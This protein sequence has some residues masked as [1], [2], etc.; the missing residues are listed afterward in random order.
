MQ[1][2]SKKPPARSRPNARIALPLLS[3]VVTLT[4]GAQLSPPPND[5]R[6]AMDVERVDLHLSVQ[7]R[8]GR[9]VPGLDQQHFQVFEDG[10]RQQIRYFS[11][12]DVPVTVGLLLDNSR[13]MGPKRREAVA[14]ALVFVGS[15]NLQD[16]VFVV[17]FN[18][19]VRFGLPERTLFSNDLQQLRA[20]FTRLTPDGQTA[21]YDALG[22]ALK[23]AQKGRRDKKVL[24]VISDGGDNA[25]GTEFDQIWDEVR[26]RDIIVYAIGLYDQLNKD[27]DPKV[28]KRL[29]GATGGEAFFPARVEDVIRICRQI[30]GE[31]RAQY[32]LG[33]APLNR[34][35]DGAYRKIRVVARSAAGKTLKV[36]TRAGYFAPKDDVSASSPS[37]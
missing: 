23:H 16:E 18:E 22:I 20:A 4:L 19:H 13:S 14:A 9:L 17:H 5:Y 7:T 15:S 10:E 30:A 12:E 8:Q 36:R 31:I 21:L 1:K 11:N 27:R 34:K 3:L 6:I 33:Y 35:R 25:S 24:I 37:Q 26:R 28:L 2:G 29:A 32:T